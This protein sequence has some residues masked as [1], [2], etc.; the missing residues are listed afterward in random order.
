M[1]LFCL[2]RNNRFLVVISA[3][4]NNAPNFIYQVF[5][6]LQMEGLVWILL[7]TVC[8]K[9]M[10]LSA[11]QKSNFPILKC[12]CL[13]L[14]WRVCEFCWKRYV[15]SSCF[16]RCSRSPTSHIPFSTKFTQNLPFPKFCRPDKENLWWCLF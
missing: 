2:R 9:S 12:K 8:G 10:F 5:K 11:A 13:I 1:R 7:K 16:K 4:I 14:K 3:K 15:G 6:T